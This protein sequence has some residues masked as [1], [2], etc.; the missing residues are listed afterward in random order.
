VNH[1][2]DIHRVHDTSIVSHQQSRR[3]VNVKCVSD[4]VVSR[5]QVDSHALTQGAE[6]PHVS[7]V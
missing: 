1:I 4:D 3:L 6:R 7:R 2:A 5:D